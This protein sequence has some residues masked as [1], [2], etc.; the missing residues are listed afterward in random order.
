MGANYSERLEYFFWK[1]P[2]VRKTCRNVLAI[3]CL[4]Y[5]LCYPCLTE[6]WQGAK[7][8][9]G[10]RNI[11]IRKHRKMIDV[12]YR[13][14]ESSLRR[15]K[16]LSEGSGSSGWRTLHSSTVKTRQQSQSYLFSKLPPEIR[17][18]IFA[19][20]V[21]DQPLLHVTI[22][23]FRRLTVPDCQ[24]LTE[25]H[26]DGDAEDVCAW[27]IWH[28]TCM[29]M[30]TRDGGWCGAPTYHSMDTS[31]SLANILPLLTTCR[32]M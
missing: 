2:M 6:G 5:T 25:E 20:V 8:G 10:L 9:N 24:I 28:L 12:K 11:R 3:T 17:R 27:N 14:R 19:Y 7:C 4:P 18:Q 26:R 30:F 21:A 32:R 23:Q 31:K 13:I 15:K 22:C 16:S 1:H 29:K